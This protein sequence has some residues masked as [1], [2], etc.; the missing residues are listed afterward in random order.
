[1]SQRDEQCR[2][3]R[4]HDVH[5]EDRAQQEPGPAKQEH[6]VT[7]RAA[8]PEREDDQRNAEGKRRA[9]Q[10]CKIHGRTYGATGFN[11]PSTAP[12]PARI[13]HRNP[14]RPVAESIGCG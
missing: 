14:I 7:Q 5:R 3:D 11:D 1:V 13:T 6:R 10:L 12:C 8:Q 4:W 9:N 2:D